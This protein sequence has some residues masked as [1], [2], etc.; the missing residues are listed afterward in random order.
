MTSKRRGSGCPL[1]AARAAPASTSASGC[2]VQGSGCRV[3]VGGVPLGWLR[4]GRDGFPARADPGLRWQGVCSLVFPV[5]LIICGHLVSLNDHPMT[6][7]DHLMTTYGH[8]V[9]FFDHPTTICDHLI[10]LCGHI[11]S[12]SDGFEGRGTVF[13]RVPTPGSPGK[14]SFSSYT[15]GTP[16][17]SHISPSILIYGLLGPVSKI[18][19]VH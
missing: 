17:Q 2:R 8:L 7:Y 19:F 5:R 4:G 14:V 1:S 15:Q 11:V 6:F 12:L 10:T 3:Q 18:I 16:T 9:W 13:P